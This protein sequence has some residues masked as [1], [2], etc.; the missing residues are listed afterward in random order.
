MPSM[1][2]AIQII[3]M[4]LINFYLIFVCLLVQMEVRGQLKVAFV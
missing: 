2:G 3:Y 1:V 4:F